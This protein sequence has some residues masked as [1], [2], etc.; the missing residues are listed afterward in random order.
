MLL[1]LL[2]MK[3]YLMNEL[4]G[5]NPKI[6]R[7][8]GRM[9]ATPAAIRNIYSIIFI[10]CSILL[11]HNQVWPNL[12]LNII[13]ASSYLSSTRRFSGVLRLLL[14]MVIYPSYQTLTTYAF[15]RIPPL[16]MLFTISGAFC[17]STASLPPYYS[18]NPNKFCLG[19]SWVT[20]Q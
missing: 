15:H 12:S 17:S 10:H 3:T 13:C 18:Y 5:N 20:L 16:Y 4:G 8:V 7:R 6:C 14:K 2:G 9:S 19:Q 1:L 11:C